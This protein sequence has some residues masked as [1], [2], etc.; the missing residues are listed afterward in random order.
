[1]TTMFWDAPG[2]DSTDAPSEDAPIV[3]YKASFSPALEGLRGG[4]GTRETSL[5]DPY[6]SLGHFWYAS[7][8][9]SVDTIL[10]IF[11]FSYCTKPTRTIAWMTSSLIMPLTSLHQSLH[12]ENDFDSREHLVFLFILKIF[13][14]L[15]ANGGV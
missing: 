4:D 9:F 7:F 1:M 13:H 14:F 8:F 15:L 3:L 6:S 12:K 10:L 11:F 2:R 5:L